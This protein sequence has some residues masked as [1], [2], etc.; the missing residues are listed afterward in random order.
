M[1]NETKAI[2]GAWI[3]TIGT[4]MSAV[5]ST[6]SNRLSEEIRSALNLWG[7]VLQGTGNGLMADA[8]EG[9]SIN[10]IGNEIQ[11]IGNSTVIAGMVIDF[12]EKTKQRLT[13]TGNWM[14]A[15]GGAAAFGE[16]LDGHSDNKA[17]VLGLLGNLLQT[18]GN[19]LQ[20]LGGI[21]ELNENSEKSNEQDSEA[22]DFSGSWIQAV[23][24]VLSL[25]AVVME[26]DFNE[27][28]MNM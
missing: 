14:Q 12:K 22:L 17:K 6:P 20:A 19:S 9:V 15:L 3:A 16:G 1:D 8:E 11:A 4:I 18:I 28:E 27:T 23:G 5:G 2:F 21:S 7:N 13:I 24:S 10:K 25:L 26:A